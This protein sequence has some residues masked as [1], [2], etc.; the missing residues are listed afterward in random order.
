VSEY[1]QKTESSVIKSIFN[2]VAG[3]FIS[4][5][6]HFTAWKKGADYAHEYIRYWEGKNV[7]DLTSKINSH[8]SDLMKR[9]S[10]STPILGETNHN[11]ATSQLQN[12]CTDEEVPSKAERLEPAHCLLL[13]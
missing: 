9:E 2:Y 13:E 12:F 3:F 4:I 8:R 11:M 10:P 7:V 6:I 1:N 5:A